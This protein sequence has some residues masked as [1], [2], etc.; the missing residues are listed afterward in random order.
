MYLYLSLYYLSITTVETYLLYFIMTGFFNCFTLNK[1]I[2]AF[3]NFM[4]FLSMKISFFPSL[5]Y[6]IVETGNATYSVCCI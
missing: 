2:E 1:N 5:T 6:S 4:F 3:S